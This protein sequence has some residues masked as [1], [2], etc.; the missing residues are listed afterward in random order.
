M[1]SLR[2]PPTFMP[3][4]PSSQPLMTWPWPM[5]T[6]KGEPRS[7]L[8]SN[9]VP[10]VSQ[11]VYCIERASPATAFCPV[12]TTR[13]LYWSPSGR[14]TALRLSP[15][16]KQSGPSHP[17]PEP[18]PALAPP[19]V[20]CVPLPGSA[21]P[22]AAKRPATI[23]ARRGRLA[24]LISAGRYVDALDLVALLH[25]LDHVHAGGDHSEVVVHATG[26]EVGRIADEDEE[27]GAVHA[28]LVRGHSDRGCQPRRRVGLVGERV[29]G[30]AGAVALGVAALDHEV[31][32]H[33]MEGQAVVEVVLGEIDEV[34]HGHRR[35]LGVELDRE[36]AAA[37]VDGCRVVL[38]RVDDGRGQCRLLLHAAPEGLWVSILAG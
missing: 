13:S 7:R 22:Q 17:P 37:R 30:P 11:P 14:V 32:Y 9:L 24:R 18:E 6:A 31:G 25:L 5:V 12:P 21:Y 29:A 15:S 28:R 16:G 26:R 33:A 10:L 8:E 1:I 20:A 3:G 36:V 19:T 4:M 34:V 23:R 2:R 38:A 27:L 35:G